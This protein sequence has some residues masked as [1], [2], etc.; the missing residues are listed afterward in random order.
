M[1][2]TLT[3]W[4]TFDSI[5]DTVLIS[6]G[7]LPATDQEPATLPSDT[8][9]QVL[10]GHRLLSGSH[11]LTA[12]Q[13]DNCLMN[14][15]EE[16]SQWVSAQSSSMIQSWQTVL[17]RHCGWSCS[18]IRKDRSRWHER[19]DTA[20]CGNVGGEQVAAVHQLREQTGT[21]RRSDTA[22][23]RR[24]IDT[25]RSC[26]DEDQPCA[27]LLLLPPPPMSHLRFPLPWYP[28]GVLHSWSV[29]EAASWDDLNWPHRGFP[30]SQADRSISLTV[31]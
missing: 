15:A 12:L 14:A 24:M 7:T 11:H 29:D 21:W 27:P 10:G 8:V 26:T 2:E 20:R 22:R 3:N 18:A 25:A 30:G 9:H 23:S 13:P 28:D 1:L 5:S 17:W 16:A 31:V 4:R 6:C 19:S